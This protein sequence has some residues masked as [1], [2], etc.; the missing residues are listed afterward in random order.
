MCAWNSSF[1]SISSRDGCAA[2][3]K[4]ELAKPNL[5]PNTDINPNIFEGQGEFG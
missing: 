3:E 4:A 2:M 1:Y 5:S